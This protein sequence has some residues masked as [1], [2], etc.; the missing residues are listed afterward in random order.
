MTSPPPAEPFV[1][2][3]DLYHA[4]GSR[5]RAVQTEAY[6]VLWD[7]LFRIAFYLTAQQPDQVALAQDC[8]QRALIRIHQQRT[9]CAEPKAFRTW[10]RRI[11]SN[12][13]IDELRRRQR[14]QPLPDPGQETELDAA[15]ANPELETAVSLTTASLRQLLQTAPMSDRSR[16]LVIGRYLDDLDDD[17]LAQSE[18]ELTGE[19][20]R[21]SH[22]QVTRSKNISKLRHWPLLQRFLEEAV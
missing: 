20:V 6:Q 19:A 4:C 7:T 8:A 12:L 5:D 16:R 22:V 14:L 21:P 10:A 3:A 1:D 2:S 17:T 15:T 11:V 13:V 9:R 18:S